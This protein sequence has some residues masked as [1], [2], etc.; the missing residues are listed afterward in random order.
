[1][2]HQRVPWLMCQRRVEKMCMMQT[3]AKGDQR[4]AAVAE[5]GGESRSL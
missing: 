5:I 1:M 2:S 4:M 3:T